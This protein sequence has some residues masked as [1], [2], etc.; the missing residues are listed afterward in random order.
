MSNIYYC[1][2]LKAIGTDSERGHKEL[3]KVTRPQHAAEQERGASILSGHHWYSAG[4]SF[5]LSPR[6][7]NLACAKLHDR[8]EIQRFIAVINYPNL[9]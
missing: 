9:H 8:I 5:L 6:C 2:R 4:S 3:F 7:T 1:P